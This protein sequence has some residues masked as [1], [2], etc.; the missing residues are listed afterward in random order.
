MKS[1]GPDVVPSCGV[2]TP[3]ATNRLLSSGFWVLRPKLKYT[4]LDGPRGKFTPMRGENWRRFLDG[5]K[6]SADAILVAESSTDA[7]G[8]PV[9]GS[10]QLASKWLQA[11]S[12]DITVLVVDVTGTLTFWNADGSAHTSRAVVPL[13]GS[14]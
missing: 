9:D 5:A 3:V 1:T 8:K 2:P 4:A 12:A 13:V 14:S 7:L 6:S 10:A 11:V